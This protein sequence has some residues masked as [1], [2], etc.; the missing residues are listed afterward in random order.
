MVR[1][2]L[3]LDRKDWEILH[4][5]AR[6]TGL[7]ISELVRRAIRERYAGEAER[8]REAMMS[9]VGSRK[10]RR[11]LPDTERYI[12]EMRKDTRHQRLNG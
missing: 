12:R 10:N 1:T 7:T 3:Y 11:D 4:L 2:Q 6:Q 5:Y 9:F 8:R